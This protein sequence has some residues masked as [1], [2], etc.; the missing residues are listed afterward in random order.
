MFS[1]MP[2]SMHHELLM[3]WIAFK[4]CSVTTGCIEQGQQQVGSHTRGGQVCSREWRERA[5]GSALRSSLHLECVEGH[6]AG[7]GQAPP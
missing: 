3:L 2:Y 7:H 5:A 1:C 4:Q 6:A